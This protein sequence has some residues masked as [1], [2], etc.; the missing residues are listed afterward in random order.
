MLS[1]LF[2]SRFHCINDCLYFIF[3]KFTCLSPFSQKEC[4]IKQFIY[5]CTKCLCI[6]HSM[7]YY[8]FPIFSCQINNVI[9][10]PS[11]AGYMPFV[12]HIL[13]IFL[14][15]VLFLTISVNFSDPLNKYI[16]LAPVKLANMSILR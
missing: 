1:I 16:S 15:P 6:L 2:L 8:A 10:F 14:N 11:H 3:G 9:A 5:I 12:R 7:V 4:I 13:L